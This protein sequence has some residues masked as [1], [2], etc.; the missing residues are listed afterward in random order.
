MLAS[1]LLGVKPS[2]DSIMELWNSTKVCEEDDTSLE[3][4]L[5][6]GRICWL[7]GREY[8]EQGYGVHFVDHHIR[9]ILNEWN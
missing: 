5:S 9:C 1:S 3:R 6:R 4:E 2:I 8:K 7:L